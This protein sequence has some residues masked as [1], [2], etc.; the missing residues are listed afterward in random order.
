LPLSVALGSIARFL[1]RAVPALAVTA[2][3]LIARFLAR[4]VPALAVT[5]LGSTM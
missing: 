3:G 1:A 4:A 5:A 2:L